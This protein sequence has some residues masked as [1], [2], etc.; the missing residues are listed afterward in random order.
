MAGR[1]GLVVM[2]LVLA[3]GLMAGPARGSLV[4]RIRAGTHS[5]FS[6]IVFVFTGPFRFTLQKI[7]GRQVRIAF[8]GSRLGGQLPSGRWSDDRIR[9]LRRAGEGTVMMALGLGKYH[10]RRYTMTR[11]H[12]LVVDVIEDKPRPAR[13]AVRAGPEPAPAR[14]RPPAPKKA[15]APKKTPDWI[16]LRSVD[17]VSHNGLS[18][19]ILGLSARP[20]SRLTRE[21]E[22][23]ILTLRGVKLSPTVDVSGLSDALI[24]GVSAE[25]NRRGTVQIRLTLKQ[26]GLSL[27]HSY[28]TSENKLIV[29]VMRAGVAAARPR[30]RPTIKLAP[31]PEPKLGRAP[32][33]GLW[34]TFPRITAVAANRSLALSPGGPPVRAPRAAPPAAAPAPA[35]APAPAAVKLPPGPA[36]DLIVKAKDALQVGMPRRAYLLYERAR[37]LVKKAR[38][39]KFQQD[40]AFREATFGW[41]EAFWAMNKKDRNLPLIAPQVAEKFQEAMNYYPKSHRYAWALIELGRLYQATGDAHEALGYFELVIREHARSVYAP[42]AYLGRAQVL[43]ARQN[44]DEATRVYQKVISLYPKSKYLERAYW[45]LG[46]TMLALGRYDYARSVFLTMLQKWPGIYLKQPAILYYL[47]ESYFLLRQYAQARHYLYWVLNI[48]PHLAYNHIALA[49]IGDTYKFEKQ[50]AAAKQIYRR[51][52]DLYP[53]SDGAIISRIRLVE[54]GVGGDPVRVYSRLMQ[55]YRQREVAQLAQLKL[56]GYYFEQK[57][58]GLAATTLRDL[59]E[60]HPQSRFREPALYV[61]NKVLH[62]QVLALAREK[63]F[64]KLINF[65]Q[66]NRARL[67]PTHRRTYMLLEAR[68]HLALNQYDQAFGLFNR[69]YLYGDVSRPVV[70]GLVR[71]TLGRT[72]Y[73]RA[74]AA[75]DEYLRRFGTQPPAEELA[76]QRGFI[77][78]DMGQPDKAFQALAQALAR[79]PL[80]RWG[81]RAVA[82]QGLILVGQNHCRRAVDYLERASRTLSAGGTPATGPRRELLFLVLSDLSS[83]HLQIGQYSAAVKA[84]RAAVE[85]SPDKPSRWRLTYRLVQCYLK[86]NLPE[87]AEA[88]LKLMVKGGDPFW[89][90]I[91]RERLTE[92]G[93]W[94]R[95]EQLGI[96]GR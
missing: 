65:I 53:D 30:L 76:F 94:R 80:S 32:R 89:A 66:D 12:R 15:P 22:R 57:Q 41:A 44:Q 60:H 46:K 23:V 1:R 50:V 45:G 36:T 90:R 40:P 27:D 42:L 82:E 51:V 52:I 38:P 17:L 33:P 16:V 49:R 74:L 61:L 20:V 84:T 58:Y 21:G 92:R 9:G 56:G 72:D 88:M 73:P 85:L 28:V 4:N 95:A 34:P 5:N 24:P 79:Y 93:L 83:C 19:L 55:R 39:Q 47:G 54:M 62:Q 7:S 14:A 71:S 86:L 69:L 3:G 67:A 26:K 68:A 48:N 11:P 2:S 96:G 59:L 29:D 18:R 25:D 35:P 81:S 37:N 31:W 10:I 6:R 64:R 43:V 13:P 75:I 63:K 87:T 78:K 91:A 77:L 8:P 70:L